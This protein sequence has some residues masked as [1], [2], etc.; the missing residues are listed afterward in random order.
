MASQKDI[1]NRIPITGA[2]MLATLM[3]TLDSTIANV[4][5]PHIQGSVSAAADQ[6]VWVLTS[7]IIA[8]AIMTPLS[9]WLSMKIGRKRMFL[10]SIAGFTGASILCGI[11]TS[12]P[13]IV[14]FRLLQGIAGASLIPLSQTVMLDIYPQRLIPR[15]M[16]VWSA[17]V[18]MGPIVGPTLGGWLTEDFSWRWVFYI[19]VPIGFLAFL[20]IW[21]FMDR[22]DGGRER[23]FDFLGFGALVAFIGGF[24]LMV[25]RGPSEDWFYSKEI[26]VE[27][28][29]CIAGLW[30]FVVQTVTAEH[31]FFHRDLAK[32][33]NFVGTTLF[34]MFV[35]VLLFS[36]SALLPL[37]MQTLLGY[38][39]LQS[40]IASMTRGV[41]SLI[42]F[43]AVPMLVARFGPRSVLLVGIL[44]SSLALWQMGKFDLS[45]TPAPIEIAGFIQGLGTGLLFAPLNTLAYAKL[46][47]IHRTEGTIVSTMARSLGSS[48]GISLLQ[49][50]LIRDSAVAHAGLATHITVTDPVL[51]WAMPPMFSL[52]SIPG[53]SALN[54]EITRQGSMISYDALFSGMAVGCLFLAPT[55]LLL[56]PPRG[57]PPS[58]PEMA[59]D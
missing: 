28:A 26:W 14:V 33:G 52:Q 48:A 5:L 25:D 23:P 35:G 31:P 4:A 45:M 46:A 30:V 34:G 11:A 17:A 56:K 10:A 37:M 49:A 40:G 1:D 44:L 16:S 36:T 42:A 51:R 3:N 59:V 39:A 53:L 8:T 18:I 2:L 43:L 20:G 24:Q 9:G 19:N 27:T 13:E 29:I 38:S 47:P 55:L 32:D 22:D 58:G 6:I 57:P 15:V 12:L 41:G 7:Y 21:T 50:M 54:G